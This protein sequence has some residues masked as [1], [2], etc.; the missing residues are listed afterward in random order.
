MTHSVD[1]WNA[2][3]AASTARFVTALNNTRTPTEDDINAVEALTSATIGLGSYI[4]LLVPNGRHKSLALTHLEDV[5]TRANKAIFTQGALPASPVADAPTGAAG[6][7]RHVVNRTI[8]TVSQQ[9]PGTD[10]FEARTSDGIAHVISGQTLSQDY[11]RITTE[12]GE[13]APG[14]FVGGQP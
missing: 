7:Y 12:P 2:A 5:L 13:I 4:E 6:T 9:I 11:E 14:V 10:A 8:I 3:H 1:D